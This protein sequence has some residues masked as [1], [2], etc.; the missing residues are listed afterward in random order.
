[1]RRGKG[2][3]AAEMRHENAMRQGRSHIPL[4]HAGRGGHQMIL[5]KGSVSIS[6]SV[7]DVLPP[8]NA[9]LQRT[10]GADERHAE[11]EQGGA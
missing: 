3:R 5:N 6:G 4:V 7:M 2:K 10:E 9:L 8:P 1:M 11:A